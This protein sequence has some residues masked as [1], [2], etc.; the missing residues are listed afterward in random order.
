MQSGSSTGGSIVQ[1]QVSSFQHR[2]Q[3]PFLSF[4]LTEGGG[5][6]KHIQAEMTVTEWKMKSE[7]W[8]PCWQMSHYNIL[9]RSETEAQKQNDMDWKLNNTRL[10]KQLMWSHMT[11]IN[12]NHQYNRLLLLKGHFTQIKTIRLLSEH[13]NLLRQQRGKHQEVKETQRRCPHYCC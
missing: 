10:M 9:N 12:K 6:R 13:H 8:C 2:P 11:K 5:L 7:P 1:L 3:P 4:P